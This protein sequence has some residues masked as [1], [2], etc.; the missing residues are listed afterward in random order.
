M[1]NS[2]LIIA[3]ISF[4]ALSTC[5]GQRQNTEIQV[6]ATLTIHDGKLAEFKKVAAQCLTSVKE[7]DTGTL[8]YD[9]YYSKDQEKCLVRETYKNSQA[10]MEHSGNLGE[11]LGQLLSVADISL[12][13]FGNPS[14]ELLSA[15]EGIDIT[16]YDFGQGL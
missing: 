8:Q 5:F 1:K 10:I 6:T 11:L 16:V 3:F 13:L 15:F 7:R 9:W 14:Q 4:A 12:D 2:F